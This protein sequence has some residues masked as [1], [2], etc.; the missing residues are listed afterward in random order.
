MLT[1]R[2][3]EQSVD[4]YNQDA[5]IIDI[6]SSHLKLMGIDKKPIQIAA[7]PYVILDKTIF[8]PQG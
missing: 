2:I 8:H 4:I 5:K 6:G 1:V 3:Y 7:A